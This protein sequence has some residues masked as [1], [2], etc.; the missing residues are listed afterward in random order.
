MTGEI[1]IGCTDSQKY[2]MFSPLF[3]Q[4]PHITGCIISLVNTIYIDLLVIIN[5]YITY[6]LLKGTGAFLHRKIKPRRL[7]AGSLAGGGTSLIILL[8]PLAFLLNGAVKLACGLLIV[9]ITFG[10]GSRGEYFKNALIFTVI[11]V[12]FAG[13]TMM[14]WLFFA[15]LGME[16]NNGVVYFDISFVTLVLTTAIAYVLIRLLRYVLD[17][18]Q[19]GELEYKIT[20]TQSGKSVTLDAIADSGNLLTDYFTGL[21]VVICPE[22]QMSGIPQNSPRLLPFNTIDSHGLIT[23][24]RVDE[25]VISTDN[26]SDKSVEALVG[27][28]NNN[29]HAIFNPKLLI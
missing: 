18:K 27:V 22:S 9:L 12:V 2:F 6:F 29:T 3:R 15:P 10:Y 23:V 21:S 4:N 13:L 26:K 16:L 7:L 8:P 20:V 19:V 1:Q 17:V 14:L 24:F 28:A 5:L 25:I 11:N